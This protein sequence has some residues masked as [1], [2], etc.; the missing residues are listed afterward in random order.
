MPVIQSK[1]VYS[2]S[3]ALDGLAS[4]KLR[5]VSRQQ[6]PAK[7]TGCKCESC[8]S[9]EYARTNSGFVCAYCRT[10]EFTGSREAKPSA[11]DREWKMQRHKSYMEALSSMYGLKAAR[12]SE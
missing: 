12:P 2:I 6:A 9:R 4:G 1:K 8:G 11:V 7:R 3:E 10:P 5:Y